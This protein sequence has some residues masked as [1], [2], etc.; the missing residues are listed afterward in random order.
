MSRV[1]SAVSDGGAT[2]A[3]DRCTAA[4]VLSWTSATITNQADTTLA[5][6]G[7]RTTVTGAASAGGTTSVTAVGR[8]AAAIGTAGGTLPATL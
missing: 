8:I 3:N 4:G 1:D 5:S 2:L 6:A 7:E